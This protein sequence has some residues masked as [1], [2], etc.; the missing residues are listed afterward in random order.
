MINFI[1]QVLI[2]TS[3][4]WK[5]AFAAGLAWYV[6]TLTGTERPYFAPLAAILCLQVTVADSVWKGYQRVLGITVG[7][8]VAGILTQLVGV[9]P[10]S[11]GILVL[12]GTALATMLRFGEQAVPQVG[13][14]AMMVLTVS[15]SHY[16]YALERIGD[17]IIGAAIAV[18]MNMLVY[19]ADFSARA[20][21]EVQRAA[22]E[23]AQH[24]E[25]IARCLSQGLRENDVQEIAV[26]TQQY[27]E[28]LHQTQSWLIKAEEARKYSPL[29]QRRES[30]IYACKLG[31]VH[32][33]Q[34]YAHAAGMFRTCKAWQHSGTFTVPEQEAWASVF[35]GCAGWIRAWAQRMELW[36]RTPAAAGDAIQSDPLVPQ[37]LQNL[38][39]KDSHGQYVWPL[40]TDATQ[41][42]EDFLT[43]EENGYEGDTPPNIHPMIE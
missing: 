25:S 24:Y 17:T 1:S 38:K 35:H 39:P 41:C 20:V 28:R 33:R 34:G 32:L 18:L 40:F 7:V 5:T 21:D 8:I 15:G 10:W 12:V 16:T 11:I 37:F 6:A 23:L 13:V 26:M 29:V 36:G 27:L 42:A 4:V 43:L 14:S 31:I 22:E 2:R 9:H 3:S 19:P 30:P